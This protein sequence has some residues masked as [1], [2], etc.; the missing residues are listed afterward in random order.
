M[1]AWSWEGC[2][3]LLSIQAG[4]SSRGPLPFQR[5]QFSEGHPWA[6]RT[7]PFLQITR[8]GG[9]SQS[10]GLQALPSEALA[11]HPLP[12]WPMPWST[13]G[14]INEGPVLINCSLSWSL[15]APDEVVGGHHRL[16][17]QEFEQIQGDSEEKGSLARCSPWELGE[18]DTTE[19]LK[20]SNRMSQASFSNRSFFLRVLEDWS[21]RSGASTASPW[22]E[23][24]SRLWTAPFSLGPPRAEW[25][26]EDEA[27][28]PVF[29]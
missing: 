14:A 27:F 20:K 9:L 11:Q 19:W 10:R 18:S 16:N 6:P 1:G 25:E 26:R 8:V 5:P 23:P 3:E 2:S 7:C 15:W 28:S 13:G 24:S 12:L 29:L 17:G 21:P 22:W 4:R